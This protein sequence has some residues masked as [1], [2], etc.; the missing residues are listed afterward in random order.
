MRRSPGHYIVAAV[1]FG[2]IGA[3]VAET[4]TL[5]GGLVG[6]GVGLLIVLFWH[7]YPQVGYA[8]KKI[9]R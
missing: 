3:L 8:E 4:G 6:I 9:D 2:V 7:A 5:L 1:V